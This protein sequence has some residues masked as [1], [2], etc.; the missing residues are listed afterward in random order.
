MSITVTLDNNLAE[1]LK[2]LADYCGVSQ[3]Q[4]A[5]TFIKDSII[6]FMQDQNELR[7]SL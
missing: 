7:D 2:A 1:Q 4:L 6:S 3:E 5:S